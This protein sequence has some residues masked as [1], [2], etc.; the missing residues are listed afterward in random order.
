MD[1]KRLAV[2][3]QAGVERD[4]LDAADVLL[5][6]KADVA[7]DAERELFLEKARAMFPPKRLIE[8]SAA[9][10]L[11]DAALNP[12][13]PTYSFALP[14]RPLLHQQAADHVHDIAVNERSVSLGGH[15]ASASVHARLER[16]ACG[17]AIPR[18]ASFNRVKLTASLQEGAEGLLKQVERLKAVLRTGIDHWTLFN[19]SAAGVSSEPC[20][21]RQDSRIEVQAKQSAMVEWP[22]WDEYWQSMLAR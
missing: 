13:A 3:D 4:Q 10:K 22:R 18:E 8:I 6:A 19:V 12:P 7:T 16:Q 9:S 21:W 1:P 20:G 5:L 17:W 11:S 15:T 14:A 2:F